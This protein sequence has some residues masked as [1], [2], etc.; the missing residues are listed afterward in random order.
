[1]S[2]GKK[3]R[4]WFWLFLMGRLR[5]DMQTKVKISLHFIE[6]NTLSGSIYNMYL[7]FF[8]MD[9]KRTIWSSPVDERVLSDFGGESD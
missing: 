8:A 7:S 9:G 1:M 4:R 6:T 2:F 5:H 3:C